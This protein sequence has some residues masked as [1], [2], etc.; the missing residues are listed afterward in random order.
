MVGGGGKSVKDTGRN[1]KVELSQNPKKIG[2]FLGDVSH[3]VAVKDSV[4]DN[5]HRIILDGISWLCKAINLDK[6]SIFLRKVPLQKR[7][8]FVT[9]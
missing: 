9:T 1:Q 8:P 3:E 4:K 7:Q 5:F 6:L 2:P